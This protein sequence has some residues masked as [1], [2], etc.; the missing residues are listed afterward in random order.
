MRRLWILLAAA[1]VA[2]VAV[3]PGAPQHPSATPEIR[4]SAVPAASA[5]TVTINGLVDAQSS[6]FWSMSVDGLADPANHTIA[7]MLNASPIR[8][9]RYGAGWVDQTNWSNGCM[10]TTSAC[11]SI[12]NN[13]SDFAT[14]CKWLRSDT[15]ILGTPGE[16]NS[17]TTL[18]YLLRWLHTTQNWYP[19]CFEIGNEPTGWKH[20]NIPWTSWA[21]G[22]ASTPT[23]TQYDTLV[24][25]YT[26]TIRSL[27]PG[28]CIV[29][30]E[31][32]NTVA[33]VG[34]I[35]SV[36]ASQ[37][38]VTYEAYHTA[39][40]QACG[41]SQTT[42]EI[43][44]R[45]NLT[46]IA[47]YDAQAVAASAGIPIV[48]EEMHLGR[49]PCQPWLGSYTDA[50]FISAQVAQG[51]ANGMLHMTFFR[52]AAMN[53][54][55]CMINQ[56]TSPSNISWDYYLYTG[57]FGKMLLSDVY[58]VTFT[59]GNP[60]T[61]MVLG[62]DGGSHK[63]LLISNA[64]ATVSDTFNLS[65]VVA[66]NGSDQIT[67]QNSTS[68]QPVTG[69]VMDPTTIV[70]VPPQST[71]LVAVFPP[72]A[73][74]SGGSGG[75]TVAPGGTGGSSAP[76]PPVSGSSASTLPLLLVGAVVAASA[77]FVIFASRRGGRRPARRRGRR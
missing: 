43:L 2:S 46:L 69:A 76:P 26:D 55:D 14:L 53:C 10:Y 38:N 37:P 25:N 7:S 12:Q 28:A 39:A 40:D 77:A 6:G 9:L 54:R 41:G 67:T 29:G 33:A 4:Q 18:T 1:L 8:T 60:E 42:P 17:V 66:A 58:N 70:T 20:W 72:S 11:G 49:T 71:M 56:S 19:N 34:W 68:V 36:A 59:G 30:V 23:V 73:G 15:C 21:S 65:G 32:A 13:V 52:F 24:R 47:R 64:N 61:F 3:A 5:G 16:I 50:A 75:N 48:V 74:S 44:A 62:T 57:L 35:S 22:D 31:A 63:T 27:D 51:L 45:T